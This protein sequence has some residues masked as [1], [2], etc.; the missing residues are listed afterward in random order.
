MKIAYLTPQYPKVSHSFIRRE[1]HELETRGHEI[2]RLSIRRPEWKPVDRVDVEEQARTICCLDQPVHRLLIALLVVAATRPVAFLDA[3]RTTLAMARPSER[4]LARHLAYLVEACFLLRIV[5]AR[6]TE[7]IHVH[8]GDN[9]AAVARLIHRLGG[10]PY[11]L[12][13]HGPGEF[14]APIGMSLREKLAEA[15]FSVA[16]SSFTS[17]QLRRWVDPGVWPRIHVVRCAVDERYFDAASRIEPGC[18]TMVYVGRLTA[19]KG[20]VLLVDAA[21]TLLEAGVDLRLILAGDGE[22]RP[23]VEE[24]IREHGIEGR[25]E[26]TGWLDEAQVRARI[27]EARCLV[28]PSFAEG[29]PVVLMEALA[30]GRPVISTFVAGIPELVVPGENG[31]LVPAGDAAALARAMEAALEAPIERLD[32][33]GRAGARR[34]REQHLLQTEVAKLDALL[35][36]AP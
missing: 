28:L 12:T 6:G 20:P 7:R 24:R 21:A 9:A 33:M 29:L 26:I 2:Q 32:A 14:D 5:E 27:L 31:W 4:G 22:L 30:L 13:I 1:I 8:F 36:G 25:V 17:A 15:S 34:V 23:A 18:R 3:L 10:P 19:Q 35:C 11:S 16:I